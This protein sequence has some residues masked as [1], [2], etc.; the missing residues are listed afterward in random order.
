MTWSI[1]RLCSFSRSSMSRFLICNHT[2]SCWMA[3]K[4]RY[5]WGQIRGFS[6]PTQ[7]ILVRLPIWQREVKERLKQHKLHINHVMIQSELRYLI[8]A[9]IVNLKCGVSSGKTGPCPMVPV[10]HVVRPIAI[11]QF[12][13]EPEPEPE[14][15]W[16]PEPTGN[17]DQLLTLTP[18]RTTSIYS[19]Y[20]IYDYHQLPK[21][22]KCRSISQQSNDIV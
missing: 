19:M 1:R 22:L 8:G 4:Y 3:C 11:V 13:A 5:A 21:R 15:E 9:K 16:E 7:R 14:L 20:I 12:R 2:N 10:L 18:A 17:L 6:K